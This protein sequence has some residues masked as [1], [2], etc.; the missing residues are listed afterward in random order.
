MVISSA[1]PLRTNLNNFVGRPDS[2]KRCSVVFHGL[3]KR[4]LY[5]GV[6]TC[7]NSF[8]SMKSMLKISRTDDNGI[9]VLHPVKLLVVDACLYFMS[10]LLLK[11][12]LTFITA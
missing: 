10:E 11:K 2:F 4:L 3:C 12:G 6:A 7:L 5:V 9:K 8:D 1:S